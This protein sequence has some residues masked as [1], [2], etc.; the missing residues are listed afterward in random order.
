MNE[1]NQLTFGGTTYDLEDHRISSIVDA[2]Y[3]VGSIYMSV[4]SANPS[5][6][7]GGTWEQI[8]DTFLLAAGQTYTAGD[9]GG[10]AEHT[11]AKEEL[12]TEHMTFRRLYNAADGSTVDVMAASQTDGSIGVADGTNGRPDINFHAATI[13]GIT[14]GQKA[15]QY[16]YGGDQPHNN[17]PPYLVVYMWRRTQ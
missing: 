3:P 17:M 7:F 9:I 10:E 6:L 4:N 1:T 12:P 15:M 11:L 14:T 5:T 8:E 16:T 13:S 2:V